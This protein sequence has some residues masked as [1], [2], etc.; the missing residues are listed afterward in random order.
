MHARALS[1]MEKTRRALDATDAWI[2]HLDRPKMANG[3]MSEINQYM[4]ECDCKQS[5]T[6]QNHRPHNVWM[7]WQ[8]VSRR[9]LNKAAR[10]DRMV[11]VFRI[12]NVATKGR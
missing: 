4:S 7:L 12:S 10:I 1:D 5:S 8:D 3:T 6:M 2:A 11:Y 9:K